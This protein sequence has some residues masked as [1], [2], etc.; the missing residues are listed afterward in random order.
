[1]DAFHQR[2]R[3]AISD[4]HLQE[5]LD[6]NARRRVGA[7][8]TAFESLPDW[9]ERRQRA[10]AVRADV[11]ENLDSYLEQF[12]HNAQNNGITVHRAQDA[13][14]AVSIILKI[15]DASPRRGEE[16]KVFFFAIYSVLNPHKQAPHGSIPS[17]NPPRHIR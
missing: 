12:I 17:E 16:R 5:A 15:I 3:R 13:A 4:E 2:I 11:I 14:E 6:G 9:P 8:V 10:H 7:R 1:M